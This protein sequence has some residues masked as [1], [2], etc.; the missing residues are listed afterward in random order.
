MTPRSL[1]Y[2]GRELAVFGHAQNWKRYWARYVKRHLGKRVL[3]VGAG[4][5]SNTPFLIEQTSEW[6]CLEP[7][8]KF[9]SILVE[10]QRAGPSARAQ[11]ISG[12]ITDL[13]RVPDFDSIIYIDVLEHIKDD[14]VELAEAAARLRPNGTLIVL[15]PANSWLFSNFDTAIGH[16]RRYSSPDMRAITPSELELIGLR[17]LD[18]VGTLASLANKLFLNFDTPTLLQILVWDRLMIPISRILDPLL[19]YKFGRSIMAIWRRPS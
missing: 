8:P 13:L 12:L 16:Y 15:G 6:I 1:E 7:D 5:G 3:E 17:H 18:S 4:I 11:K 2:Q 14:A 10:R 19:A 9:A